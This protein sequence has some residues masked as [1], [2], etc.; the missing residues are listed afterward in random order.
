MLLNK[1]DLIWY[2]NRGPVVSVG[3]PGQDLTQSGVLGALQMR[4]EHLCSVKSVNAKPVDLE[5]Q[6]YGGNL[7]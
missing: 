4:A 2:K 3:D 1:R 5:D 7:H 6:L